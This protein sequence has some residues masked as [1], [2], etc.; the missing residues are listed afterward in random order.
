MPSV[1][2]EQAVEVDERVR[3]VGPGEAASLTEEEA[4]G[5]GYKKGLTGEWIEGLKP[6][7]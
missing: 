6:I 2:Y 1:L 7:D 5:K 4:K 3:V